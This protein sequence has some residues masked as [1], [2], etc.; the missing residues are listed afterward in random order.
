MEA[1]DGLR[2]AVF[3]LKAGNL[4]SGGDSDGALGYAGFPS[5]HLPIILL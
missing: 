2:G 4:A 3:S 5:V 1:L